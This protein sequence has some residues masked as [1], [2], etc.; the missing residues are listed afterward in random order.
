MKAETIHG[1]AQMSQSSPRNHKRVV[2]D[3]RGMQRVQITP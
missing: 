3:E 2:G 1:T